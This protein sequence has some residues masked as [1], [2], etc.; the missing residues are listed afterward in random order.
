MLEWLAKDEFEAG[1]QQN[2]YYPFFDKGEWELARFLCDNLTQAQITWFLK[3]D[4]FNEQERPTFKNASELLAWM[5]ALPRAPRWHCTKINMDN[6]VTVHPVYLLWQD[7]LETVEELF[8]N[9]V[10]CNHMSYDPH[11]VFVGADHEYG[12]WMTSREVFKI[13]DQLPTGATIVPIILALDKT[14]VTCH[15]GNLEMHPLFLTIGN[16][17]A[18]I[19]MKVTMH[20]WTCITYM[21]IAQFATHSDFMSV[22]QARLWHHCMD[23]ICANLKVTASHGKFMVDASSYQCHTQHCDPWKVPEFLQAAKLVGL[24]VVFLTPEILHTFHKFFF[25][26][27]LDWCKELLRK[28][29]LDSH[30]WSQ[31]KHVGACHFFM[32][33]LHI[34]QMTCQEHRDVQRTIIASIAGPADQDAVHA[35]HAIIN[36]IYRVQAPIFT[37]TSLADMV[38]LLQEFH[39]YKGS[40]IA[41]NTCQMDHF[42]IPKLELMH[43]FTSAVQNVSNLIQYMAD[44][45]FEKTTCQC[46]DFTHQ[47]IQ[48]LDC[49]ETTWLFSLFVL[50]HQHGY[51]EYNEVIDINPMLEWTT[52]ISPEDQQKFS[53]SCLIHNHFLKGIVSDDAHA[54]LHVNVVPTYKTKTFAWVHEMYLLLYF[55]H[56]VHIYLSGL[57]IS[58]DNSTVFL[59]DFWHTFHLQ[60]LSCFK[61]CK[62]LLSQ[63]V[64][65]FPPSEKYPCGYSDIVMVHM[66]S[67][68]PCIVQVCTVFKFSWKASIQ[69]PCFDTPLLYI[70]LFDIVE[71][72]EE[73]LRMYRLRCR[74]FDMP[75]SQQQVGEILPITDVIHA[76]DSCMKTKGLMRR[77][78]TGH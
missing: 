6:Y 29:E 1:C 27:I 36:F 4:W 34:K 5:E 9:P 37:D 16:I 53:S 11:E 12:E 58:I 19:H 38:N 3:L 75:S 60:L 7:T 64:Q 51:D 35:I 39:T 62:V 28:D 74:Y 42:K 70:E 26:H 65:A 14:P 78:T 46:H 52:C 48:I 30:Y 40:I 61:I 57:A 55:K 18:D 2:S 77:K 66:D 47:I 23:I 59:F 67:P 31:H 43:S 68:V 21:P 10:F 33:V 71:F 8:G 54:A 32:G 22:L 15:T 45:P 41:L 73:I 20:A 25:D 56:Y 63:Q 13:Q 76:V 69:D 24:S 72:P 17:Q 49:E 50:L 44:N